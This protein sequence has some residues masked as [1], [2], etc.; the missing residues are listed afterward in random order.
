MT[1]AERIINLQR[2]FNVRE[3]VTR[4]D[5]RLPKRFGEPLSCGTT[6]GQRLAQR[7]IRRMLDDYYEIRGWDKKTGAPKG[8]TLERLGLGFALEQMKK[9][10][11]TPA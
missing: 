9:M 3:G 7:T 5:D 4:R 1:I 8:M 6:K 10:G 11:K 2:A